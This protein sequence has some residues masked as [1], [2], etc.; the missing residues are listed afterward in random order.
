M[1]PWKVT[2]MD[3]ST[4]KETI[5]NAVDVYSLVSAAY[6]SGVYNVYGIIKLERIPV[7]A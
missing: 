1:N 4:L 5:V 2:W 6:S 3:G 7:P